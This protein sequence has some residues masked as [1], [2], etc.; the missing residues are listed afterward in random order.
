MIAAREGQRAPHAGHVLLSEWAI[1]PSPNNLD[2]L[3]ALELWAA[4]LE[5]V[6]L[7]LQPLVAFALRLVL[8][9]CRRIAT[10]VIARLFVSVEVISPTTQARLN[11]IVRM[12]HCQPPKIA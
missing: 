3:P 9:H 5:Q 8:E 10:V 12:N 1:I 2:R 11:N 4:L 6:L 7:L